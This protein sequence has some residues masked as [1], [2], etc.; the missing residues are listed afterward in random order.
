MAEMSDGGS[1]FMCQTIRNFSIAWVLDC[2]CIVRIQG[3]LQRHPAIRP[4]RVK[5]WSTLLL[6][7]VEGMT[8]RVSLLMDSICQFLQLCQKEVIDKISGILNGEAY[9]HPT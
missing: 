5:H 8:C 7:A 1:S 3:L 6:Q 2:E 9:L 4:F